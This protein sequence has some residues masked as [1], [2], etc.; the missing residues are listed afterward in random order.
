VGERIGSWQDL[1]GRATSRRDLDG[2]GVRF[3]FPT[4]APLAVEVAR[5]AAAEQACCAFF[6]FTVRISAAATVLEVRAP[7]DARPVLDGLFSASD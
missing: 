5:L 6:E 1:L 3:D 7:A 2:G 4:G